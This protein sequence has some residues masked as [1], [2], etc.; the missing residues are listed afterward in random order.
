MIAALGPA[1]TAALLMVAA[2]AVTSVQGLLIRVAADSGIH[3]FEVAFF[4][5]FFGF[6]AMAVVVLAT[7]RR[8]PRVTALRP[9]GGSSLFH[10]M[11]MLSFFYGLTLMPLSDSAAL[12]FT[13]PLFG[14]LAAAFFL[15]E[16]VH[17]RRWVAIAIGFGGVII[18]L[19]PGFIPIGLGPALVL[20]ST[21]AFAGVTVLVKRMAAT[22]RT[23][24]VVFYQSLFMSFLTLPPALL[25]WQAP[26]ALSFVL[27]AAIGALSTMGWIC[28]TRAFALADASAILPLEF[29]RLPFV[30][31][32]A[33]LV[34]AEVPDLWVW[35]GAVV[36]FGSSLS[37]AHRENAASRRR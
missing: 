2:A 10:L 9:I 7:T 17:A 36:I 19:R 26:D 25:V 29:T 24:T 32:L 30:A 15:G 16:K 8:V 28:F 27:L 4:R 34:F 33:Y 31:V 18:V 23:P 35:I 5:S 14:T 3:A 22:E 20:F 12:T 11:A 6:V 13:A 37:I 1:L 21:V